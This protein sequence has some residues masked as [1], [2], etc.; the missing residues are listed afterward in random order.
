M[1]TNAV[2][3]EAFRG[4]LKGERAERTFSRLME[5]TEQVWMEEAQDYR[6]KKSGDKDA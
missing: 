6:R 1:T 5:M 4:L 3:E 2:S